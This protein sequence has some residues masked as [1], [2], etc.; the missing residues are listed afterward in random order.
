[1]HDL[2]DEILDRYEVLSRIGSGGS[3][4]VLKARDR[5]LKR[6]VAIKILKGDRS[7]AISHYAN[8][9]REAKTICRLKHPNI[10]DVYDFIV[11]QDQRPV[12][13]MEYVSGTSLH[14]LVKV[15][16]PLNLNDAIKIAVEI[17]RAMEYAH[18]E[19]ILHRDL[20]PRNVII[21]QQ[22]HT[23]DNE[24]ASEF[25]VTLLDFGI[26]RNQ[27]LQDSTLS[28]AG[29]FIGTATVASPEQARGEKID[30][31]SDI[32][33]LGCTLYFTLTGKYPLEGETLLETLHKQISEVPPSLSE[34]NFGTAYPAK[35]EVIVSR[36]IRKSPAERIQ[37]M[38]EFESEL[39]S[40]LSEIN[41][42]LAPSQGADKTNL[43]TTNDKRPKSFLILA[44]CAAVLIAAGSFAIQYVSRGAPQG[45]LIGAASVTLK[46]NNEVDWLIVKGRLNEECFDML[47]KRPDVIR[48]KISPETEFSADEL[49]KLMSFKLVFLDMR[50][51]EIDDNK[52]DAISR[53]QTLRSLVLSRCHGISDKGLKH[54]LRLTQLEVLALDGTGIG[55]SGV[56]TICKLHPRLRL[57]YLSDTDKITDA[58]VP[59]LMQL[60]LIQFLEV[61]HTKISPSGVRELFNLPALISMNVAGLNLA[62]D[63][64]PENLT[65]SYL[66]L[67]LMDNPKLTD[68]LFFRIRNLNLILLDITDCPLMSKSAI[69]SYEQLRLGYTVVMHSGIAPVSVDSEH[70]FDPS[71][72]DSSGYDP[73]KMKKIIFGS[74][75]WALSN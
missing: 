35:L 16:G 28:S 43:I 71:L 17:C 68:R 26:A 3:G 6:L 27:N 12:M 5:V 65:S 62:D 66:F 61:G 36:A 41:A 67:L 33:S 45:K 23:E 39:L 59:S 24:Q 74:Q 29:C 19:G 46:R 22:T 18:K 48:V 70:Y 55:D 20:T 47:R 75:L 69:D 56:K 40:V 72:Y 50:D 34:S 1:V 64:I 15:A 42:D 2:P 53:C 7:V 13:L 49:K 51:N 73:T 10:I 4:T 30:R 38:R 37:S 44:L 32:Y 8:L 21:N 25:K 11:T 14:Q 60:H 54:L 52:L 9:Q 57:L 63:D 31:R 58:S